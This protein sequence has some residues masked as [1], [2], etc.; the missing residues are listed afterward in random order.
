MTLEAAGASLL[1]HLAGGAVAHPPAV[2]VA[3]GG[4]EL[5]VLLVDPCG[6]TSAALSPLHLGR[7]PWGARFKGIK[8]V[9]GSKGCRAARSWG[10][11]RAGGE[12]NQEN[13]AVLLKTK[14]CLS[15]G[16]RKTQNNPAN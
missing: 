2:G 6:D 8:H 3:G 13:L 7:V 16:R 14:I 12:Q 15:E 10:R 1:L 4:R 5:H 11:Q 9:C